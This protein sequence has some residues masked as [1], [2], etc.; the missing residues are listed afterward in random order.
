MATSAEYH[1]YVMECLNK[2]GTVT[3]KKMMGEY[4]L[5]HDGKLFGGIYDNRLLVKR[6]ENSKKLLGDCPLEYPY[7]GSKSL[8]FL[9][10]EFE[11]AEFMKKLL[12]GIAVEKSQK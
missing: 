1:D 10:S 9:V 12:D 3:S 4:C 8:M 5:Y 2:A 6:T 7:E 11:D